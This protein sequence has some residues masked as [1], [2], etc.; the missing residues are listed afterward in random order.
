MAFHNAVDHCQSKSGAL[1]TLCR[2]ERFQAMPPGLFAH[3]GPGI[4]ELKYYIPV[5][6]TCP[7]SDLTAFG[8]G[9]C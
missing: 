2:V 8:H 1:Q 5:L 7:N 9:V 6:R 4:L 3:S